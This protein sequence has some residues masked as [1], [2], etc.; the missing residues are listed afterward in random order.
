MHLSD[1]AEVGGAAREFPAGEG[2]GVL[3]ALPGVRRR[4][5]HA[6]PGQDLAHVRRRFAWQWRR[7]IQ[8][9]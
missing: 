8:W 3:G 2:E 7:A 6:V 9:H 5:R 1:A 4:P